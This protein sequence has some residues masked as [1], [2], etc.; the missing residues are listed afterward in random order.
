M[1]ESRCPW[2][3][4]ALDELADGVREVPG[5]GTNPR[6]ADYLK[7][8]DLHTGDETPWCSAF[9][10]WAMEQAKVETPAVTAMARSWLKWGRS[11]KADVGAVAVLWR[12]VRQ[13]STG[14]VGFVIDKDDA[15]VLLLGG[16]Q[17]DRVSVQRFPLIRVLDFRMPASPA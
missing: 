3:V 2:L 1:I 16:N 14:H 11:V 4:T 15:G 8:V 12:G 6:I 5:P 13:S 10:C 17:G 7:A 9:A